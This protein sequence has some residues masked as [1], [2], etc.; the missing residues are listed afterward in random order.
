MWG[1]RFGHPAG[2]A[3]RLLVSGDGVVGDR[4]H[5]LADLQ[6]FTTCTVGGWT[7]VPVRTLLAHA[8]LRADASEV[9][10]VGLDG[11]DRVRRA[12][13]LATALDA[14]VAWEVDG[15]SLPRDEG[16]PACL[17]VPGRTMVTRLRELRVAGAAS[18][19]VGTPGPPVLA[20]SVRRA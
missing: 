1:E 4:V 20:G 12:L 7:G 10:A 3:W 18:T 16:Y 19:P 17:V 8:G 2:E 11:R 5:T 6:A 14:L 13:A 9:T 15:Q